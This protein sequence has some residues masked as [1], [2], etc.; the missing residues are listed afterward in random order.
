MAPA[1]SGGIPLDP[2]HN[3]PSRALV[4][5]A[6]LHI[7]DWSAI[8]LPAHEQNIHRLTGTRSSLLLPLL[9]GQDQEALGV[10]TFQRDKAEPFS[11][12]D[13]ALAQS[14]ADQ[15]VIAIEN[16]RLFNE[17]KEAL[18]RQTATA[19]VLEVISGSMAD[20]QPVFEKILDSCGR[21]F[22]TGHL[23]VVVVDDEGLVRPAAIRGEIVQMMTRTLPL[24]AA[25][26]HTGRAISERRIVQID[27]AHAMGQARNDDWARDTVAQVG[28]FSAAWVPMLWQGR[29]VGSLMVVRQ[30]PR[31]FSPRDQALLRTFADQA[32]VAIQNAHQFNE[33]KQALE[34]QTATA[35][36]LQVI[37]RSV[38][39]PQPVFDVIL[40]CCS[41]LFRSQRMLLLLVGEDDRLHFAAG[42]GSA[43]HLERG[44]RSYP[45]PIAGTAS[46]RAL[47]GRRVVTY[48][49]VLADPNS[50]PAVRRIAEEFGESFAMAM[51]PL[52][53]NDRGVGV[54]NV[55]RS[56]GDGFEPEELSLL[57]T[58]ADQPRMSSSRYSVSFLP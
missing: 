40:Q 35:E 3:F 57:Q 44:R 52:L 27:D 34:R 48:R 43:S 54:I 15:A 24:P 42:L 8:D 38:A 18:E 19:E 31:P 23:G 11:E 55:I 26:S 58:F 51:A 46:E 37:S 39:E 9:R 12:A 7:P 53:W 5:R 50:P 33:T 32:V 28:N 25:D 4:S 6:L 47:S 41:R 30:P 36:V 21:L 45:M 16:V 1:L 17:T 10:L 22:G 13:I 20:A 14:F 49:D 56:A 2:A 29:G